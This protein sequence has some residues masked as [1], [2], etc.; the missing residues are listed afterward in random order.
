MI[1]QSAVKICSFR[2]AFINLHTAPRL[3]DRTQETR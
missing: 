2:G 3:Q 1:D